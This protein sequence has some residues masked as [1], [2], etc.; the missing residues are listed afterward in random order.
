MSADLPDTVD[1]NW[2]GF[3]PCKYFGRTLL[4]MQRDL[5]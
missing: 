1:L 4:A 2:S 3:C 5:L